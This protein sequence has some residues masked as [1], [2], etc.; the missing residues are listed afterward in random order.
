MSEQTKKTKVLDASK[1]ALGNVGA[2]G[3]NVD[4][5]NKPPHYNKGKIECH[6]ALE[7]AIIGLNGIDAADTYNAMKYLWRWNDKGDQLDNLGKAIV[8]INW[9]IDR[10]KA[11][12]ASAS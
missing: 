7:S 8:Y 1:S 3:G 2:L 12:R 6:A 5:V 4:M 9:L 11:R 10:E